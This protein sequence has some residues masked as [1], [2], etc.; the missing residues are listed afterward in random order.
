MRGIMV[1]PL[2]S[3]AR[4]HHLVA[5]LVSAL[6]LNASAHAGTVT[7]AWDAN[8]EADLAGYV[9]S[10]GTTPGS[11]TQSRDVGNVVTTAVPNLVTGT[12]YYFAV[13]AY[14]TSGLTSAYSSE[15]SA[16]VP[17]GLVPPVV[18]SITPN[19]GS[20]KG[21]TTVTVRGTGFTAGA[22][23]LLGG[24]PALGV[25][26]LDATTLTGVTPA[27]AAGTVD[28][29]VVV[30]GLSSAPLAGAFTFVPPQLKVKPRSGGKKGGTSL[31]ISGAT[32][33]S[34][35]TVTIGG[36]KTPATL[37]DAST[38]VAVAP[39][40]EP[41]AVLVEVRNPSGQTYSAVAFTYVDEAPNADSD[42]DGLPDAWESAYG[43]D[44]G[45]A[46]GEDG[47]AGDPDR[48]GVSNLD[49]YKNGT[50]PRGMFRRH[51]AEGSSGSFFETEMALVN[52]RDV[53]VAAVLSFFTS[54]GA[55]ATRPMELA[56]RSRATLN[57]HEIVSLENTAFSTTLEAD[58]EVVADRRMAW[59]ESGYGGHAETSIDR[60]STRWYFAEGA[61][62]SGF[63][64]FYLLQ[65]PGKT[66]AQVEIRYLLPE[67]APVVKTY[68]LAP[69][70]RRT[71]WVDLEDP[72]LALT[73]V[74]AVITSYNGVP[75]IAERAMYLDAGGQPFGAGH[76]S[77]GVL[78]PNVRWFLAEG[79][80]G[81]F[82]D[83]FVLL[84]NP[85][86]RA[87]DVEATYLLPDGSTLKKRYQ[88]AG[89]SRFNIWV[90]HQ[91]PRL[92]DT[93]V[94]TS[95]ESL[96]G[97]PIIVERSMWWPGVGG[98]TE[99]HN[100]PGSTSTASEWAV[101]QGE[102]GGVRNTAT[103][104]LLA[105]TSAAAGDVRV[106]LLLEDGTTAE[107]V[108]R[109]AGRSRFNVNVGF[110]F[111]EADNRRFGA[112]VQGLGQVPPALVVECAV[113]WDANGRPWAA[114]TDALGTPLR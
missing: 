71:I 42:R 21:G 11:Y 52:P 93:A 91:D 64:L 78:Q 94:S 61:T 74:S 19:S 75:I 50:H 18:T 80:T 47:A 83:M 32:F 23:L 14:N 86:D 9:V 48:D 7:L 84:A 25:T 36:I 88:V 109:V 66:A 95:V 60:A 70:S 90:D 45:S 81:N 67:G 97:V 101:A 92:A 114:G 33:V 37:V 58:G 105:N 5:A 46:A 69:R 53:P 10:W 24:T 57:A 28:V 20:T 102:Q 13:Q 43:L 26:V 79:A 22:D 68:P 62:H 34:G 100:A 107:R 39:A 15:V 44:P 51:F 29:V 96:N 35:A 98:W 106:T 112:L 82:F 76:A 85:T 55:S 54:D 63:D 1:R 87:A 16:L 41:G 30:N 110:E 38:L 77:A 89:N 40:H 111:P 99:A 12:R 104:V 8:A 4:L 27:R 31:T 103:Y 2:G 56:P 3:P 108:F 72:A 65:N 49:E 113:Y 17:D 59:D 6:V 73:D